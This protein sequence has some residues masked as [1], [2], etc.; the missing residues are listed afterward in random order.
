MDPVTGERPRGQQLLG[1][2]PRPCDTG[3]AVCGVVKIRDFGRGHGHAP[4][5]PLISYRTLNE[6][7]PS[8]SLCLLLSTTGFFF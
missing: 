7:L 6:W 1:A 2:V 4:A 3:E 5:Q 8:L